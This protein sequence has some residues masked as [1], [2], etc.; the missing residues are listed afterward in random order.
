MV[1][2]QFLALLLT[3]IAMVPGGAH[4]ASLLT[5]LGMSQSDYF[6]AQMAYNG[7]ALF[8]IAQIA[9]LGV[10]LALTFALRAETAP[11]RLMLATVICLI[12]GLAIFFAFTYPVNVATQ[13][14]TVAPADWPALRWRWEVSH[15]INAALT[16]VGFGTLC[17]AMLLAPRA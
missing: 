9:A 3:A 10:N 4:A 2:L 16:L 5:K 15:A 1:A 6:I 14:W 11:F 7:W 8:G 12:A 17:L 13:N